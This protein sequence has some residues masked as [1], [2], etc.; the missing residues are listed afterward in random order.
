MPRRPRPGPRRP[1][2]PSPL[3]PPS[4]PATHRSR[5]TRKTRPYPGWESLRTRSLPAGH[6]PRHPRD[7]RGQFGSSRAGMPRTAG[8]RGASP[9]KTRRIT[10]LFQFPVPL[11]LTPHDNPR[12]STG[13]DRSRCRSRGPLLQAS[14]GDPVEMAGGGDPAHPRDRPRVTDGTHDRRRER[15]NVQHQAP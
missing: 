14:G 15:P 8:F 3:S 13:G 7:R 1:T 9:E 2:R 11:L 10:I 5:T 4:P 12:Q 6:Q